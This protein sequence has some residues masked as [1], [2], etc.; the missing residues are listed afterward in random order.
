M[1]N[2]NTTNIPNNQNPKGEQNMPEET[3]PDVLSMYK[4][5]VGKARV[6]TLAHR[7][8]KYSAVQAMYAAAGGL[9]TT[10]DHGKIVDT[11]LK[12]ARAYEG[13]LKKLPSL[14]DVASKYDNGR[15][16]AFLQQRGLTEERIVEMVR[17]GQGDV[18]MMQLQQQL[19]RTYDHELNLHVMDSFGP[20]G[21]DR[22]NT[23]NNLAQG[24]IKATGS[25]KPVHQ[26]ARNL[27]ELLLGEVA[28]D[29]ERAP[30]MPKAA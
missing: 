4:G 16:L 8:R 25:T 21:K 27:E 12:A 22:Y 23:E 6:E 10:A 30:P 7:D 29:I 11:V 1:P 2:K 14:G 3:K 28:N 15:L 17:T 9:S 19:G 18:L 26:V 24:Y 13:A 20:K 5:F